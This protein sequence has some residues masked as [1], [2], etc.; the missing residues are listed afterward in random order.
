M[1]AAYH[2]GGVVD[3]AR[4]RRYANRVS[5]P[6][7]SPAKTKPAA[8]K[9]QPAATAARAK[10]PAPK[11]KSPA[12]PD[13]A[14]VQAIIDGLEALSPQATCEL[15]FKTPFQLLIATIL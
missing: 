10:K 13:P 14:R 7:K 15:D 6:R 4:P 12:R 5:Q 2:V 8:K 3:F 1:T 11:L 9:T